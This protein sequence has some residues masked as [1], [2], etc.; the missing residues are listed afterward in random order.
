M[1][2]ALHGFS[3]KGMEEKYTLCRIYYFLLKDGWLIFAE[4]LIDLVVCTEY[5]FAP[6][7]TLKQ[8]NSLPLLARWIS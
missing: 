2:I 8:P 7:V 4:T 3:S 5:A 1:L 6:I